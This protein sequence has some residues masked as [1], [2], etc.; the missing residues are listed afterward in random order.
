MEVKREEFVNDNGSYTIKT[1]KTKTK[2]DGFV[3]ES[4]MYST[5]MNHRGKYHKGYMK[6]TSYQT[7]DP[8]I[9]RPFAYGISGLFILI[10][11]FL[12]LFSGVM[13]KIM[14]LMFIGMGAFSLL[15]SKQDID[16]VERELREK[17]LRGDDDE[18]I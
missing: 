6:V 10:G 18:Y 4:E 3:P 11:F 12:L 8:R 16:R 1:V 14:A 17:Q 13:M 9:T 15:K 7:N 2:E 5:G